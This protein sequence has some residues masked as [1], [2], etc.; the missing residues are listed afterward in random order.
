VRRADRSPLK[1]NAKL[2]EPL[3]IIPT[4]LQTPCCDPAEYTLLKALTFRFRKVKK[5]YNEIDWQLK[6]L[7]QENKVLKRKLEA[8]VPSKRKKVKTSPNS[9]FVTIEAIRRAKIKAGKI[10]A[11]SADKE[12]SEKLEILESCIIV[13][14]NNNAGD[15]K[16]E[17]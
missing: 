13:G 1:F 7:Q 6:I 14:F 16:V 4:C 17:G 9:R 2:S 8:T 10:K 3:S 5:G 15:N 12:G 11:E